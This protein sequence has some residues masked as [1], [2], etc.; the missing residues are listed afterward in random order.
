MAIPPHQ[1]NIGSHPWIR[2]LPYVSTTPIFRGVPRVDTA[3]PPHTLW[4]PNRTDRYLICCGLCVEPAPPREDKPPP[5]V[6]EF[7]HIYS[8]PKPGGRKH[9]SPG[10]IMP[11]TCGNPEP[12]GCS[13][14]G[15]GSYMQPAPPAKDRQPPP[16]H[17]YFLIEQLRQPGE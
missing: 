16:V 5:L 13:L 15:L 4:N 10:S 2:I 3:T 8:N 7:L 12:A 9:R 11:R 1:G 6:Q 17:N 14:I